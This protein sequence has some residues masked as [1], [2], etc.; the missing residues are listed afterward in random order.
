M[1]I[2]SKTLQKPFLRDLKPRKIA[3]EINGPLLQAKVL[4]AIQICGLGQKWMEPYTVQAIDMVLTAAL[5][6]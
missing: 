3:S 1:E 6:L 2:Y 4:Q 5:S